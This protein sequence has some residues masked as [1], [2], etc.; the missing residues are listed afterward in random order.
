MCTPDDQ[1]PTCPHQHRF[2]MSLCSRCG[3][4]VCGR[5]PP[6]SDVLKW[7]IGQLLRGSVDLIVTDLQQWI[8]MNTN[9][10]AISST[11]YYKGCYTLP[12]VLSSSGH[13]SD[14]V[15]CD[16][17]EVSESGLSSCWVYW[18]AE[19]THHL[20]QDGRSQWCVLKQ[21]GAGSELVHCHATLT[22][23]TLVNQIVI[24]CS[25]SGRN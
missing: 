14:M 19:R 24:S 2:H 25:G 20:P 4:G 11:L 8:T 7:E 23:E 17:L 9:L 3:T 10:Q 12:L 1:Y 13:H 15:A 22:L 6:T 16:A 21:L 18:A 5:E